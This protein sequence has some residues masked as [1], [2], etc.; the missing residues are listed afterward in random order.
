M[1]CLFSP[2]PSNGDCDRESMSKKSIML[3]IQP[4][5]I[6]WGLRHEEGAVVLESEEAIQ[7]VSIKW[8]LRRLRVTVINYQ[9][10]LFSP[11]PSN[12]DCAPSAGAAKPAPAQT[13][14]FLSF[15]IPAKISCPKSSLRKVF[16]FYFSPA[17]QRRRFLY[18]LAH[19]TKTV[20]LT[21]PTA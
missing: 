15:W 7:S 1:R 13:A 16:S 8:G 4:V 21:N 17:Q 2:Y 12:G 10:Q 3:T 20:K 5:S 14:R 19:R 11:Y 6:K 9:I 18:A